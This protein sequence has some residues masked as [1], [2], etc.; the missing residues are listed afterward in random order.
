MDIAEKSRFFVAEEFFRQG[1]LDNMTGLRYEGG[2]KDREHIDREGSFIGFCTTVALPL[3]D[4]VAKAVPTL[5]LFVTQ[6]KS[7]ITLWKATLAP[8]PAE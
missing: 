4:V 2:T 7:N 8:K 5:D 6:T 1:D 3:F